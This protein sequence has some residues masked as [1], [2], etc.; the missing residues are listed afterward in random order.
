MQRASLFARLGEKMKWIWLQE[1]EKNAYADFVYDFSCERNGKVSVRVASTNNYV[2]YFNGRFVG[3]GQYQS[4]PEKKYY[5][6]Y[7][8]LDNTKLYI[9]SG[10]GTN[11]FKFR[12]NSKPSFNLYRLRTK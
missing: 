12:F 1:K 6:E 4:Y 7:Y 2:L 8:E 5:D 11:T 9:S 3:C 10:I